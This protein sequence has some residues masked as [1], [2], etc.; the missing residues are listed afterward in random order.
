MKQN[1]KLLALKFNISMKICSWQFILRYVIEN[2]LTKI[3]VMFFLS[4]S[5]QLYMSA[6][7]AFPVN[8]AFPPEMKCFSSFCFL[9]IYLEPLTTEISVMSSD[10]SLMLMKINGCTT[11]LWEH[12][13][14][15]E[16]LFYL[17][18]FCDSRPDFSLE[19]DGMVSQGGLGQSLLPCMVLPM[20]QY[21]LWIL[22]WTI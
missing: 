15:M 5:V 7:N 16:Y 17:Y 4:I 18:F 14:S 8:E 1:L 19:V 13:N 22:W 20:G 2:I 6:K 9:L 21:R 3:R 12:W 10:C 11:G